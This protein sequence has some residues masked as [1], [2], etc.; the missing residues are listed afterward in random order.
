MAEKLAELKKKGSG[1]GSGGGFSETLLWTNPDPTANQGVGSELTLSDSVLNYDYIK[2][3]F[4]V[5]GS[6]SEKPY[7][8]SVLF[9]SDEITIFPSSTAA[10]FMVGAKDLFTGKIYARHI[11][12]KS[13]SST[14]ILACSNAMV[15][16]ESGI[17]NKKAVILEIS[18]L[19]F[20]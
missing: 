10:L 5:T 14:S 11:Y 8:K 18:G 3:K 19:K 7:V 9:P 16:Q 12:Y 1:G 6:S 13:S 20:S 4:G 15:C 2:I 17:D